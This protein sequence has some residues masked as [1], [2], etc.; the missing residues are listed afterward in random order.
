MRT[1]ILTAMAILGLWIAAPPASGA[2]TSVDSATDQY[3]EYIPEV[4]GR[5]DGDRNRGGKQDRVP[6]SVPAKQIKELERQ[7]SQGAAAAAL[8][9]S[10]APPAYPGTTTEST[11]GEGSSGGSQEASDS[12][13]STKPASPAQPNQSA[14]TSGVSAVLSNVG[15]AGMGILLPVLMLL[16]VVGVAWLR[17]A[18]GR[19]D[20]GTGD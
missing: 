7:G 13:S 14:E 10:T 1:V 4:V 6:S 11:D 3:V 17:T 9:Q 5:E 8:A 20:P 18:E 19:R 15:G 2:G 16:S 12:S